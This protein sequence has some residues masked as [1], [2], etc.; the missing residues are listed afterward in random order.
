MTDRNTSPLRPLTAAEAT[1]MARLAPDGPKGVLITG[2][3]VA[4]AT[5]H[6]YTCPACERVLLECIDPSSHPFRLHRIALQCRCSQLSAPPEALRDRAAKESD[7]PRILRATAD[8]N[9]IRI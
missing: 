2:E 4:G 1:G 3:P 5:L 8:A 6:D 7:P 9:G